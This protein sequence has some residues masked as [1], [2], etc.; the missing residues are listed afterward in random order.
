M[1]PRELLSL[2]RKRIEDEPD[3]VVALVERNQD[4]ALRRVATENIED[5]QLAQSFLKSLFRQLSLPAGFFPQKQGLAI[6]TTRAGI[7]TPYLLA[8]LLHFQ[9]VL[10]QRSGNCAQVTKCSYG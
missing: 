2:W 8:R 9:P 4:Q 7:H 1:E 3:H 10:A 6:G 5:H